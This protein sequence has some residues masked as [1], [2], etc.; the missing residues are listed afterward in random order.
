MLVPSQTSEIL[1]E[2][3]PAL[4]VRIRISSGPGPAGDLGIVLAVLAGVGAGEQAAVEHLLAQPGRPAGQ[5]G[6]PVD[7]VDDEPEP[8]EV[9]EHHHVEGRGGGAL[10]L[11]AASV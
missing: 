8:V 2:E 1:S 6:Y 9:V 10:F 11:V 7:H 5:P 4:T 3:L